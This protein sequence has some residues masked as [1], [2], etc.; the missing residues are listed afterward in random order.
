MRTK[1][2]QR[3]LTGAHGVPRHQL[4]FRHEGR[5]VAVMTQL[6]TWKPGWSNSGQNYATRI[7]H[8]SGIATVLRSCQPK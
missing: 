1:T 5:V 3:K 6:E 7:G 4:A 2:T 8:V